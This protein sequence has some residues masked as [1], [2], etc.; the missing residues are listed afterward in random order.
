MKIQYKS[1]N[2]EISDAM[3]EYFS[4]KMTKLERLVNDDDGEV[5]VRFSKMRQLYTVEVTLKMRSIIVRAEE[6]TKDFY[7][8]VD[9]AINNL[10]RRLKRFKERFRTL[11]REKNV[12]EVS[13]ENTPEETE[14]VV[15]VKKFELR[16][17][18]LEEAMMQLDLLDHEFF[19]FRNSESD[20]INVLYRRK[21]GNYGLIVPQ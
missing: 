12:E 3:K 20:Q 1:R 13:S 7:A 17:M 11:K 15:K 5:E 16:P 2:L 14:K 18:S 8:S 19:M 6:S 10:E 9:N 21:D 4:K